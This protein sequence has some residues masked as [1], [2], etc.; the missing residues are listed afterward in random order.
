MLSKAGTSIKGDD[1][2]EV[3]QSYG[4]T[5]QSIKLTEFRALSTTD[6]SSH[7][8][9]IASTGSTKATKFRELFM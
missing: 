8:K 9:D 4:H 5:Q 1:L 3:A 7:Y 6:Y 2:K